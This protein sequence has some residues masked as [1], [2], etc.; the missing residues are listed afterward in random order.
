M[1]IKLRRRWRITSAD[2]VQSTPTVFVN[3]KEVVDSTGQC[4]VPNGPAI[5]R[6]ISARSWQLSFFSSFMKRSLTEII[7]GAWLLLS[8]WLLGFADISV[9]RWS[10][11]VC[12]LVLILL[13]VWSIFGEGE[14]SDL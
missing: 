3:G 14:R 12:G 9:M 8:P 10:D 13:G 6:A 7:V 1:P 11:V 2:G 4:V 5:M